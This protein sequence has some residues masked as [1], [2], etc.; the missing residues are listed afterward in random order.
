[1]LKCFYEKDNP[2]YVMAVVKPKRKFK[3]PVERGEDRDPA[4]SPNDVRT[5]KRIIAKVEKI[6]AV[7]Q[8]HEKKTIAFFEKSNQR[9]KK[10]PFFH[11]KT[12]TSKFIKT[13]S[14]VKKL[15]AARP[16]FLSHRLF[17]DG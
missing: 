7:L 2:R 9:T 5:V 1:V 14:D 15:I 6:C 16:D 10:N 8:S 4:T 12:D 3:L 13:L 11:I 17:F